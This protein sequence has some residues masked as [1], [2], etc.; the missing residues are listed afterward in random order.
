MRDTQPAAKKPS[1]PRRS[2][3][4]KLPDKTIRRVARGPLDALLGDPDDPMICRGID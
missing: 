1:E 4:Q 3:N 2:D